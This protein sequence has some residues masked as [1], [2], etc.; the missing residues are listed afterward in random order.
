[1]HSHDDCPSGVRAKR[2][3]ARMRQ[4][5]KKLESDYKIEKSNLYHFALQ[6]GICFESI[7]LCKSND[8]TESEANIWSMSESI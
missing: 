1:M 4:Q 2:K 5:G 6:K 3:H 8:V 7:F